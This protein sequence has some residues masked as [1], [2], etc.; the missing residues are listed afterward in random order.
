[1]T[2]YKNGK[3]TGSFYQPGKKKPVFV[4]VPPPADNKADV[5]NIP[6]PPHAGDA[7]KEN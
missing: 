2:G 3:V 7:K 4:E 1:M 6:P 5:L